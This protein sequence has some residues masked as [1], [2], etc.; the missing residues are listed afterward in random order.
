[1]DRELILHSQTPS[2]MDCLTPALSLSLADPGQRDAGRESPQLAGKVQ[3]H[4]QG[5]GH[6]DDHDR[7]A[8]HHSRT[9]TAG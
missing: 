7:G 3:R 8:V 6:G 4:H 5:A 1:M 2:I 9:I